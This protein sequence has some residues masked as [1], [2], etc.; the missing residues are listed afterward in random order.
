MGASPSPPTVEVAAVYPNPAR[1]RDRGEFVVLRVRRPTD[2]AGWSLADDR[3]AVALGVGNGTVEGRV[4]V[5]GHPD[6]V[7][8]LTETGSVD[9]DRVVAAD[10]PRLSNA[11]ERVRLRRGNRTVDTVVY[12]DAPERSLYAGGWRHLDA[13]DRAPLAVGPR[14]VRAFV[15][16]DGAGVPVE[17]LRSAERR[18][19]LAG[20]T[21]ESER[22]VGALADAADRGV[23]VRVL[24][25]AGPVGGV[26]HR[27]VRLLDRLANTSGV[28]VRVYGTDGAPYAYHHAKYAV[29][30]D[31]A[32]VT[33]ENWEPGGLGGA[34]NRGWG[35]VVAGERVAGELAAVFRADAGRPAAVP[36]GEYRPRVDPV[37]GAVDR[38][39]FPT[40]RAPERLR[41]ESVRVLVAPDN[42]ER[43][44]VRAIEGANRSVWVQQVSMERGPLL[45]A[46]VDAACRGAQVRVL[47][48]GAR[49]VREENERL[50]RR[51]NDRADREGWDLAVRV[52]GDPGGFETIHTKGAVVDDRVVLGSLNWNDHSG[53]RNRE[54]VLVLSGAAVADYYRDALR[55]DWRGDGG[56]RLGGVPAWLAL[57]VLAAVTLAVAVG[58]RRIAFASGR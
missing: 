40:R 26:T 11:G 33:T 46:T 49:Y 22:A 51:L 50:A 55:S 56:G 38:G 6:V 52:A 57:A 43:G 16:P 30:D 14:S 45:S 20:Y 3:S 1:H 48:S 7:R 39:S 25:D 34:G 13:T 9:V 42:A 23:R 21:F 18:V 53:A 10:L 28:D 47:L 19:L 17:T 12:G 44:V 4:A 27:Q 36:W 5:T 8:N 54:V 29:V 15:L 2:L 24:V 41:V 35:A 31:R 37:Y 32:L 58:Y